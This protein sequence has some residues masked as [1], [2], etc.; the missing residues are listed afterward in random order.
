[1]EIWKHFHIDYRIIS[2]PEVQTDHSDCRYNIP[3]SS[4]GEQSAS[5]RPQGYAFND[6]DHSLLYIFIYNKCI[7]KVDRERK[8]GKKYAQYSPKNLTIQAYVNSTDIKFITP[9]TR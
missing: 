5:H 2:V 9:K 6:D 7:E 4:D 8:K 1:M 3:I